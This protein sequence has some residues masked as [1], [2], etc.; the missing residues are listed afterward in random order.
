MKVSLLSVS[1]S[2]SSFVVG[3]IPMPTPVESMTIRSEP[4]VSNLI[5]SSSEL[6]STCTLVSPSASDN[7]VAVLMSV[8]VAVTASTKTPVGGAVENVSVVPL[9]E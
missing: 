5:L 8:L 6:S 4:A 7:C 2:K 3:A 9:T 1:I